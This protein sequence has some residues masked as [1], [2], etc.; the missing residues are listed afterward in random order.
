MSY[1]H[2]WQRKLE[3]NKDIEFPEKLCSAIAKITYDFSFA[4][5]QEAFVATLLAIAR[6][7]QSERTSVPKIA[8]LS[9]EDGW[10]S[11]DDDPLDKYLLWVEMK[12]QVAILREGMDDKG[13]K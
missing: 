10:V 12:K 7:S 13:D 2:F 4:Y 6:A 9:L 5:I 11:V 8:M 3:D 1:C